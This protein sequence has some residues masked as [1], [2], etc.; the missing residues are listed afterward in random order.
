MKKHGSSNS[1]FISSN[2]PS[3]GRSSMLLDPQ[4]S[5]CRPLTVLPYKSELPLSEVVF[6]SP[7]TH[8]KG[9]LAGPLCC[10]TSNDCIMHFGWSYYVISLMWE[11]ASGRCHATWTAPYASFRVTP[12]GG[13]TSCEDPVQ[14]DGSHSHSTTA[15]RIN[16]AASLSHWQVPAS[17][18]HVLTSAITD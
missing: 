8:P 15:T 9:L 3:K 16:P 4:R 7:Y 17:C 11:E 5:L 10:L 1:W 18:F 2:V 14:P 13:Q 12:A 6:G